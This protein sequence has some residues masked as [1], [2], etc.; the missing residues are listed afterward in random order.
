[1]SMTKAE[2][3]KA[4]REAASYEFR[5]VPCNDSQIQ[6][7]FSP[8]FEQR[9]AKLIQKEKSVFWHFVNTASKR[10]AA[11]I[12]VLVMLFTTA[13]SVKAIRE[14]LVRFLT[15]VHE[16]FT[17]YFFDGEKTTAI[18][19][20]Y[21][22]SVIPN[23][24]TEES[25][26]ETAEVVNSVFKNAQ[27]NSIHFTQAITDKTNIFVDGEKVNSK[28]ITVAEHEATLYSQDGILFAMWTHDGYY[29]EVVCY[30]DFSEADV[31]SLIQSVK[32]K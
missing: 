22:I 16:T 8:E 20:K 28:T 18:T 25:A 7:T 23:G 13:C 6:H 15:E 3:K 24:F 4:F 12:I 26:V 30:G 5:D 32:S 27:G 11:I 10:A 31:I 1:M 17:E 14:P 21:Q 9:I 2:L 19:K 29:F